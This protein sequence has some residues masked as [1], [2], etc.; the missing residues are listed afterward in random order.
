MSPLS[1]IRQ[2]MPVMTALPDLQQAGGIPGNLASPAARI[3]GLEPGL[4]VGAPRSIEGVGS[5]FSDLLG[6]FVTD[7]NNRQV[8]SGQAVQGL[9]TGQATSLHEAMIA[10]EEASVSFHLMVEVRNKLLESYQEMM[11]MQV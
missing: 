8:A 7:V 6:R 10:M 5:S 11:R 4:E 1:S 3:G 2:F 9:Q